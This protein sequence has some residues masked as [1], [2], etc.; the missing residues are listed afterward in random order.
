M[1]K[2]RNRNH[3]YVGYPVTSWV[4]HSSVSTVQSIWAILTLRFESDCMLVANSSHVGLSLEQWPHL[5]KKK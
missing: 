2:V 1:N 5:H 3:S 4:E